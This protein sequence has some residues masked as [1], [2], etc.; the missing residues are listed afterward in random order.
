MA[1]L[2][3]FAI[4][5]DLNGRRESLQIDA[6]FLTVENGQNYLPVG[7]VYRDPEK[8]LIELPTE[9]D[10][11]TNRLWVAPFSIR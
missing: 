7:V 11:G 4:I 6:D 3:R 2:T 5:K 9:A 10:S 1:S 8:V